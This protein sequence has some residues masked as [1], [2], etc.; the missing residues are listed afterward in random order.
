MTQ[1]RSFV[2][3]LPLLPLLVAACVSYDA[4]PLDLIDI[5]ADATAVAVPAELSFPDAVGFALA[6]NPQLQALAAQ[7]R[8]AGADIAATEIQGQ[9]SSDTSRMAL[10]V[11][12]IA[13]LRLGQRGA[14][15]ELTKARE[16]EALATLAAARWRLIGRIAEVFAAHR[17]LLA[18][19]TPDVAADLAAFASAGLASPNAIAQATA[20]QA[21]ASAEQQALAA[22]RAALQVELRQLLG[23]PAGVPLVLLPIEPDF[24]SPPPLTETA[25]LARPDLAI[26]H[27]RYEVAEAEFAR[28]CADQYPSLQ[29]GPDLPLGASGIESMAW[30]KIPLDASGPAHAARQRR[31]AARA[32][33]VEA[34]VTASN[35]ATAADLAAEV[36]T[37]KLRA[38]TAAANASANA[39]RAARS[40]L[41]VEVDVFERFAERAAMAVRDAAEHR[42]AAITAARARI[43]LATARGW[44]ANEVHR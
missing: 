33:L 4:Q 27:A 13:L 11:D 17:E 18:L 31:I 40:A 3:L 25:L 20:A 22:E 43:R 30:F 36:A 16:G 32:N 24:P 6:H 7:A 41:A 9:W 14:A 42:T 8:A 37:S 29:I 19:P 12:P 21:G 23:A 39:A 15:I 35:E 44:P 26:Q 2:P 5:A 28:T 38:T 1:H 10:M 34:F